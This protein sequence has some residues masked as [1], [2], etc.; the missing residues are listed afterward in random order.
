MYKIRA[1]SEEK[2]NRRLLFE[3]NDHRR[4][5]NFKIN[6]KKIGFISLQINKKVAKDDWRSDNI[7]NFIHKMGMNIFN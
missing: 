2:A 6:S 5:K 4:N 3:I 1:S 7:E